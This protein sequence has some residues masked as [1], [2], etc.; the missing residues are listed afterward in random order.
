M[1]EDQAARSLMKTWLWRNVALISAPCQK[2]VSSFICRRML[3]Q[4]PS[5]IMSGKHDNQ[6]AGWTTPV[7]CSH[8]PP[9]KSILQARVVVAISVGSKWRLVLRGIM[10]E[11]LKTYIDT[12]AQS[13]I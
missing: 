3:L 6:E 10:S 1:L 9:R 7:S 2:P 8:A 12:C 4:L 5:D 11:W 13:G